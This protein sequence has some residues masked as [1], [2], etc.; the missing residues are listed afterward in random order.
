M[1]QYYRGEMSFWFKPDETL[2]RS[3]VTTREHC[4]W[5]VIWVLFIP[6]PV[7]RRVILQVPL[8]DNEKLAVNVHSVE[9]YDDYTTADLIVL[10]GGGVNDYEV[11][12]LT[13]NPPTADKLIPLEWRKRVVS[14]SNDDVAGES[15]CKEETH[16]VSGKKHLRGCWLVEDRAASSS[17]EGGV[18]L[19]A[20]WR[21][22]SRAGRLPAQGEVTGAP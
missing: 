2:F 14:L 19:I 21:A 10:R 16:P 15:L 20:A 8:S 11:L 3:G 18:R 17:A 7:E 6:I 9:A 12:T 1:T 22:A 4:D 5:D 13:Y